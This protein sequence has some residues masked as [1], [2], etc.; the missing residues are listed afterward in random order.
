MMRT[1][2]GVNKRDL[3]RLWIVHSELPATRFQ[4]EQDCRRVARAFFAKRWIFARADPGGNPDSPLPIKHGIVDI[5]LAVPDGFVPPI[6][7]RCRDLVVC[8][9]WRLRVAN[10]HSN[11]NRYSPNRIEDR[12]I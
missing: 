6:W 12:Q 4:G 3:L 11:L 7:R 5:G 10:W 9:R 1:K 8:A 2:T